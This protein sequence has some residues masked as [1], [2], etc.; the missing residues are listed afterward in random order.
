M[1]Y[2][3]AYKKYYIF[4]ILF[5]KYVRIMYNY[6]QGIT[7]PNMIGRME[8]IRIWILCLSYCPDWQVLF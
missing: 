2:G 3:N 7:F 4:E 1:F 8:D 6:I 5:E